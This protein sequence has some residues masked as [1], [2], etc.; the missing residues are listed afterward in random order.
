MHSKQRVMLCYTEKNYFKVLN[1]FFFIEERFTAILDL[2]FIL[3]SQLL[4]LKSHSFLFMEL[5]IN[6]FP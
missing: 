2:L 1:Q 6:W 3:E 4:F 5:N